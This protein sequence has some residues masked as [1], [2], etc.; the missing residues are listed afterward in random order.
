MTSAGKAKAISRKAPG[1]KNAHEQ[2]E[3]NP[4]SG[5][6]RLFPTSHYYPLYY[7]KLVT[8]EVSN[9]FQDFTDSGIRYLYQ[10]DAVIESITPD[11]AKGWDT[12]FTPSK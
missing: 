5:S 9:N 2:R 12:G 6:L 3:K 8:V 1:A 4:R 7:S 11:P 10:E